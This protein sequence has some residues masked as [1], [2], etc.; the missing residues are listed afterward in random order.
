[1]QLITLDGGT[2]SAPITDWIEVIDADST[3][4]LQ[5]SSNY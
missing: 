1:M 4:S 3:K 5:V 2:L